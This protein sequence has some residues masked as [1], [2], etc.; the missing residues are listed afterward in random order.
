[1][2]DRDV[3]LHL[4]IAAE[5]DGSL[6]FWGSPAVRR[7]GAAPGAIVDSGTGKPPRGV[8]LI[9]ADTLRRD[10]LDLYGYGR[11]T[12]PHLSAAARNGVVFTDN[13]SQAS[14]TKVS[15]SSMLS[16]LYPTTHG[17]DDPNDRL[18]SVATTL[19]EVYREAG[20]ATVSIP[21]NAFAGRMSNLHQGF[22]T[23]YE[24]GSLGTPGEQGARSKTARASVDRLL[25]WLDDHH[26]GP[27]FAFIL[28]LDPHSPFRPRSPYDTTWA[29]PAELP[30]FEE[31][32]KTVAE[33]I[34]SAFMKRQ[35]LPTQKELEAAGVA[36]EDYVPYEIDWYD[37]SIRGMDVEIGRLFERLDQ[38]GIAEDTLI[39]FI[40]DHGEE[41]LEHG[42]HWHG[43][44]IYGEMV[45]VPLILHWSGGL[46]KG[47]VIEDTVQSIDLMPT[48][49]ELSGL[50]P[51]AGVQG[52]SL[53]PLI[54]GDGPAGRRD[55]P[56]VSEHRIIRT[57][58]QEDSDAVNSES[59]I[60]DG[61]KLIRNFDRPEEWPEFELFDHH[62]DPLDAHNVAEDN[63]EIV[64]RL[65]RRLDA[66]REWAKAAKLPSDE[67]AASEMSAEELERLRA[68]G[69]V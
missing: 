61:W 16:S 6:G 54:L 32:M 22:E 31:R 3:T 57:G 11:Q 4:S 10:H 23:V 56:I 59:I 42:K 50:E 44:T 45:N 67:E 53:L 19:A 46:P 65:N 69:Y 39:A 63:P 1:V 33:H 64:E 66:W 15:M 17:I 35:G 24:R 34:E 36:A 48:L 5:E 51:P 28:M 9:V 52:H 26:D 40:A 41:F 12:T 49:L 14:W 58:A 8:I 27:F 7:R 29:D 60:A 38:L 21:S 37:G 2:R 20:Y 55:R 25:E 30:A 47:T 13:I 62:E 68:L 18:S 43:N